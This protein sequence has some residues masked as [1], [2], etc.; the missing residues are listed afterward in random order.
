[1][2]NL[3]PMSEGDPMS[4]A[5]IQQIPASYA[6]VHNTGRLISA[7]V[8]AACRHGLRNWSQKT[9]TAITSDML[10]EM[11]GEIVLAYVME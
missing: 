4:E 10:N 2:T 3:P 6:G 9:G 7:G 11:I 8:L 1:M 5:T